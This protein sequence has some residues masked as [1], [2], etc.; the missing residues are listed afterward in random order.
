M[1]QKQIKGNEKKQLAAKQMQNEDSMYAS[2]N[3]NFFGGKKYFH[4]R[5]IKTIFEEQIQS[6]WKVSEGNKDK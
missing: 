6:K 5:F 1:R 4:E 3:E 2:V